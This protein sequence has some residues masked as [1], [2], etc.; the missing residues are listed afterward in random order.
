MPF[1]PVLPHKHTPYTPM[2]PGQFLL[3]LTGS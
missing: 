3:V 2:A 1:L